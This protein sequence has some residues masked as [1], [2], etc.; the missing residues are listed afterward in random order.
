MTTSTTPPPVL[1]RTIELP[2]VLNGAR[3]LVRPYEPS[4]GASVFQAVSE[5][6]KELGAIGTWADTQNTLEATVDFCARAKSRWI[7]RE[8]MPMG[9]WERA[10][11][12]YL[13]GT[14][15]HRNDWNARKF[16]IGYWLRTSETKKGYM[17]ETVCV[18]TRSAFEDM[19]AN[20]VEIRCDARNARSRRVAELA[21]FPL[22]ATLRRERRAVDGALADSLI[23]AVLREDYDRLLPTWSSRLG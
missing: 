7:D 12:R 1:P 21:G 6:R 3:V 16:E 11:A 2:P 15:F 17:A 14:G 5:S 4:D 18:L 22:E 9:V 19:G 23:F 20:R 8:D 13:G 10:T